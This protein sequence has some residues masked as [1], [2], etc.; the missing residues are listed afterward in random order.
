MLLTAAGPEIAYFGVH[1]IPAALFCSCLYGVKMLVEQRERPILVVVHDLVQREDL[2]EGARASMGCKIRAFIGL[3]AI[4]G[5]GRLRH[6]P[7]RRRR[8]DRPPAPP[9]LAHVRDADHGGRDLRGCVFVTTLV[10]GGSLAAGRGR[11]IIGG[12]TFD[13]PEPGRVRH[14]LSDGREEVLH[15]A[16]GETDLSGWR[17]AS[18][19]TAVLLGVL[20]LSTSG[21]ARIDAADSR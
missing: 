1:P 7:G 12:N 19:M 5:C 9:P 14:R 11:G 15:R 4:M 3:V 20:I 17:P 21:P 6:Q 2:A 18:S 16:V 13:T 8:P 10:G